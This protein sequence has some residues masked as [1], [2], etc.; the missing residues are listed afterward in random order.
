MSGSKAREGEPMKEVF[1]VDAKAKKFVPLPRRSASELRLKEKNIEEWMAQNPDLLFT[2]PEAI[3]VIGQ[4]VAGEP[5]ADLLAVDSQG[6]LIVIEAKRGPSDRSNVAQ[7]LDYA[8]ALSNWTYEDFSGVWQRNR[9][10]KGRDLFDAFKEEVNPNL[11]KDDFLKNR[12]F[13]ILAS[14][15]DE[16]VKRIIAWLHDKYGVPIYFV[17]FQLYKQ[18]RR[19]LLEVEKIRVEPIGRKDWQGDWYFNTNETFFKGSYRKML[20]HGVIAVCGF[21]NS[22]DMLNKP[23]NGE[24]IFAY[25]NRMGFI[26]AGRAGDRPAY[27]SGAVFRQ[28]G[29]YEHHRPVQWE[30]IVEPD[31]AVKASEAREWGYPVPVKVALCKIYNPKVAE[32]IA[33]ELQKRARP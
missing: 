25:L 31:R 15:G 3:L 12:R 27:P 29:N 16:S 14:A 24:R 21:Y 22:E 10:A 23:K 28:E 33:K 2:D 5:M 1:L 17:P 32:K 6:T 20:K 9:R 4:E 26:A 13:F 19:V 30:A 18:G 7:L 11:S 8:A